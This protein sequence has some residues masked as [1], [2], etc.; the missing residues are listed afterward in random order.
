MERG[1]NP[2]VADAVLRGLLQRDRRRTA[3]YGRADSG[4]Q[5]AEPVHDR[6]QT[7][8]ATGAAGRRCARA[9][10][11]APVP[12]EYALKYDE[13][14]PSKY[15]DYMV[16]TG[17]YMFKN[18]AEGKVLGD[19]LHRRPV[20]DAGAQ[21]ELEPED[22]LPP[23]VPERNR[24]SR[25]AATRRCWPNRPLQGKNIVFQEATPSSVLRQAYEHHRNQL[26]IAPGRHRALHR[27][28]QRRRAR[29]SNEDLRKALYVALDRDAL[30]KL[31]GGSLVAYQRDAHDLPDD[32]R[33]RTGRGLQGPAGLAVRLQPAFRRRPAARR[34]IH[35]EGRLPIGQVHRR[36]N[37]DDRRFDGSPRSAA[38]P[39][40]SIRH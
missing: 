34:R 17:P 1:A 14:K 13:Q 22:R 29:S 8:A 39:K 27:R 11:T 37:R 15:Y 31:A 21:P 40:S 25:S 9:A 6:L 36:R 3:G 23:R 35:Q 2:N 12:K 10:L 18:N 7:D 38:R 32:P 28:E 20:G 33:L 5:D 24:R 4:D 16:A 26:E 30:N 19:R